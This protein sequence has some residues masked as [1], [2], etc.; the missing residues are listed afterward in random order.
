MSNQ[1]ARTETN[2]VHL[3]V[4][5]TEKFLSLVKNGIREYEKNGS[6]KITPVKNMFWVLF[7]YHIKH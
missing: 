7:N 1:G 3:L 4:L 2:S 6:T 5:L